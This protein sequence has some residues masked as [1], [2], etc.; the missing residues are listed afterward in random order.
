LADELTVC[1]WSA[2]QT[3]QHSAKDDTPVMTAGLN[4]KQVQGQIAVATCGP[5][6]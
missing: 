3:V 6:E 2:E 5:P 4:N 1:S